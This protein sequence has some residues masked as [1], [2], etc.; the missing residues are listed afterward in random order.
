MS[1]VRTNEPQVL[2]GFALIRPLL[3]LIFLGVGIY[4][5]AAVWFGWRQIVQVFSQI[6]MTALLAGGMVASLAYF[7]RFVRWHYVLS[8]F[9]HP[10]PILVNLRFYLSGLSLTASPGKLGETVR[11]LLLVPHGVKAQ[12]SLAAFLIDRLSDVLGVCLLGVIAGL[13]S[14][15]PAW[16]LSIF[17]AAIFVGSFVFRY[18]LTSNHGD[19][20][21]EWLLKK[22]RKLPLKDLP[23]ILQNWAQLWS[24]TRVIGF[25]ALAM[26]AYGMQALVFSW[27]C[28]LSG[29]SLSIAETVLIFIQATLFG[30]A[31]L[32][33]G[34]LGAMEAALVIQLVSNGVEQSLAVYVAIAT[35]LVTFWLGVLLGFIC[36]LISLRHLKRLS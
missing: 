8:N 22:M 24:I 1:P 14:G 15:K 21:C 10:I 4:L 7:W 11:T 13:V 18:A 30:A 19:L 36:L 26:L 6:G 17:F 12:K 33:P 27:F 25:T 29:I 20:F 2:S 35:R 32:I 16:L 34:G 31:S 5:G 28:M 9:G 3:I 23:A